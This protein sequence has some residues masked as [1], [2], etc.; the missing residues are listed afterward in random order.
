MSPYTLYEKSG[1]YDDGSAYPLTACN[2]PL[3]KTNI[4]NEWQNT[5]GFVP[6]WGHGNETGAYRRTWPSESYSVDYITQCPAETS[7]TAF[8]QSSDCSVLNDSYPSFVVEVSCINA[9]P[10][11][12]SN[13]AYSLL[14]RGAV[15]TFAGTRVTWYAVAIWDTTLGPSYG[16]N[17]SYGYYIFKRMAGEDETAATALNWCKSNFSMGFGDASWMNM[18]DFNLYGDPTTYLLITCG[19]HPPTA[20]NGNE[21]AQQGAAKTITLQASDDGFP[22]PPGDLNYI[23]TSLPSIGALKDPG[24]GAI[25]SVPY[26]LADNGNQVI[27]IG[28][29]LYLGS[30]N[31]HFKANDGGTPPEGGD[32]GIATININVQAAAPSVIYQTGF[33][34]G[35]PSGW[36]IVNGG[37]T[38][39]TWTDTNPGGEHNPNWTGKFM[40]VDSNYAGY[41]DPGVTMDEQL[42]THNINCSNLTDVTLKFKHYFRRWSNEIC[43]VDVRIGAGSWQNV[44]RYQGA[45]YGGQVVLDISSIADGQSNVKIRWHYYNAYWEWYWGI[46]DVEI[47]ASMP[48]EPMAGDFEPDCDIDFYDYAVF[49]S[50]W[51][52][53]P[54]S[55]NWNPDCDIS[56]P[57][58]NIIDV[59][60]L[61][62]F[63]DNWLLGI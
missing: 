25:R 44:A 43:D 31:F 15:G 58:D 56:E 16:D 36:S 30:D 35:L 17:A 48:A 13:L 24:A 26:T 10:E 21:T 50:A 41:Q 61:E 19:E 5:Y 28:C 9:Y 54:G 55:G 20:Y 37:N 40:I 2:A 22:N 59:S 7:D 38:S 27:Y 42:I 62:V 6:W 33:S 1:V 3:T 45:D 51:L 8:F 39:D 52:S 23:I 60:D 53:S 18:L 57:T 4:K 63:I 11:S 47:L 12:S 46:D 34:T 32:S 49:A 29:I 14:K